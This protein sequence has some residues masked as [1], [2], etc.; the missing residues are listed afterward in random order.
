M[1]RHNGVFYQI[2]KH[3]PRGVFD[4]L[5]DEHKANHQVFR[6]TTKSQLLALLFGQ[7]SGAV[8][9]REIEAVRVSQQARLDHVGGRSIARTT[10]A[11]ANARRPA[12]VFEGSVC[13]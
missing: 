1:R 3:V 9:L 8:S 13:P 4:S 5:V 10:L 11:E 2:Q 7:L 6:L 12:A